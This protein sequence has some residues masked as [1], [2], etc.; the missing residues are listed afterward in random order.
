LRH[1]GKTVLKKETKKTKKGGEFR[2]GQDLGK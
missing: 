1:V 2:G